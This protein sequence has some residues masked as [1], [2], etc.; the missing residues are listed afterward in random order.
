MERDTGESKERKKSIKKWKT[1]SR[2]VD[3]GRESSS[4]TS[5]LLPT[6]FCCCCCWV[7]V[8]VMP[9]PPA[10][11]APSFV[12]SARTVIVP[13]S[14]SLFN[15]GA[16]READF[17]NLNALLSFG[18]NFSLSVRSKRER[19]IRD[20]SLSLSPSSSY[21]S[22]SPAIV[23]RAAERAFPS[24]SFVNVRRKMKSFLSACLLFSLG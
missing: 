3:G 22:L 21:F 24:S 1:H 13:L 19:S 17:K 7:V 6:R 4:T 16:E 15:F 5:L 9:P 8:V 2:F 23:G 11:K 20:Y 10:A 12:L 18:E 14:L